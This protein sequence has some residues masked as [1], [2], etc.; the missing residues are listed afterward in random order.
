VAA[1]NALVGWSASAEWV[2]GAEW[3]A[4]ADGICDR[5]DEEL[6]PYQGAEFLSGGPWK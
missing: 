5:I 3:T 2:G 4:A 1:D 6:A